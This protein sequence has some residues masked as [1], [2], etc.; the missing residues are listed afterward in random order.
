MNRKTNAQFQIVDIPL[1][2]P[3]TVAFL[4]QSIAPPRLERRGAR[5]RIVGQRPTIAA[6]NA[7]VDRLR[8]SPTLESLLKRDDPHGHLIETTT[9]RL[10]PVE[11]MLDEADY[12]TRNL[13][14]WAPIYFGVVEATGV[15]WHLDPVL[16]HAEV[17]TNYG[18]RILTFGADPERVAAR[19]E[20]ETGCTSAE[21]AAE[22]IIRLHD[23]RAAQGADDPAAPIDVI[24]AYAE[25]LY[26]EIAHEGDLLVAD[27]DMGVPA[28]P[29]EMLLDELMGQMVRLE[30]RRR[31]AVADGN[32]TVAETLAAWQ[33]RQNEEHGLFLI[34]KGEYIMGR[35][36]RSTVLI[37]PELEL[38]IKQPAPEP[39]HEAAMGAREFNGKPENW[40][41][42]TRDG[43][44]VTP[45]GRLRLILEE[46]LIERLNHIFRHHV[47]FGSLLGLIVEPFITGPTL[48]EYVLEDPDRIT[49]QVYDIIML[50]QQTCEQLGVENGDW[51]S[52][53]FI[54]T[55]E[56]SAG[57]L[58]MVHIDWGAAR[59]LLAHE[60]T[61]DAIQSRVNQVQNIAFSFHNEGLAA[62]AQALHAAY[63]AD[64]ERQQRVRNCAAELIAASGM[65]TR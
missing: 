48:Q 52:A 20:K 22:T 38:V 64:A 27:A 19:L 31:A 43:A 17:L 62:R 51:H 30:H 54:V 40:P 45:A 37:A 28:V 63:M 13:G 33:E 25:R 3:D 7:W 15:D 26:A 57:D 59:P 16:R 23:W 49:P 14:G 1:N 18:D 60:H 46:D 8:R 55:G 50:H 53:N 29:Q 42:L 2:R 65:G 34:L 24:T 11:F 6:E 61:P 21:E 32:S 9:D 10:V 5:L 36:R 41:R 4:Q 44:L 35:H 39:F 12:L 58:R 56:D 47:R